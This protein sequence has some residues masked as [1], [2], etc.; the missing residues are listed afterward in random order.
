M[1]TFNY[2]TV[3]LGNNLIDIEVKKKNTQ[4]LKRII[5]FNVLLSEVFPLLKFQLA[6]KI[7]TK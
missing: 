1:N 4:S 2:I 7:S 6:T 3:E 5:K